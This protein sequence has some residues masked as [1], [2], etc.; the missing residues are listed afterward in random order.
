MRTDSILRDDVAHELDSR[1]SDRVIFGESS[2]LWGRK[3]ARKAARVATYS[4]GESSDPIVS[5]TDMLIMSRAAATK[6]ITQTKQAGTPAV[7]W[8]IHSHSLSPL[9]VQK[10]LMGIASGWMINCKNPA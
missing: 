1:G 3:R 6:N 10:A 7:P 8:G 2:A 5:S 4:M 9:G